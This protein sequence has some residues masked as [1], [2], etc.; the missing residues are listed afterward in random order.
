MKYYQQLQLLPDAEISVYVL[1]EKAFQQVHLAL[2]E[3]QK[4]DVNKIGITFPEYNAETFQLGDK[5]RVFAS[6]E[7]ELNQLNLKQWFNRLVDYVHI[8][9]VR[10]V[11]DTITEYVLFKGYR[12]KSS[13]E[14]L[15]RRR[16]KR[17]GISFEK[18]LEHFK[19]REEEFSRLPFINLKSLSNGHRFKLFI[20]CDKKANVTNDKIFTSY[21]LGLNN[22]LPMF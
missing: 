9:R 5:L 14:R 11:P 6:T 15:A 1:W 17:H 2:A 16:A 7:E 21:G 3:A 8:S 12:P 19:E 13:N 22:A 4:G 20:A 10:L 18:A